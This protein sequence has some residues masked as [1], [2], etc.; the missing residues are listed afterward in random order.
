MHGPMN[1]K[2]S[3]MFRRLLCHLQGEIYCMLKTFV[4]FG[5]YSVDNNRDVSLYICIMLVDYRYRSLA[6][7]VSHLKILAFFI[8]WYRRRSLQVHF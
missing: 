1:V 3:Y 6:T 4:T 7:R 5:F 8:Y 2:I